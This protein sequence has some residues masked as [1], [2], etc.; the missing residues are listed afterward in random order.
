[1]TSGKKIVLYL[2]VLYIS[3]GI[4][5]GAYLLTSQG[6]NV[7]VFIGSWAPN[8]S[9]LIVL[10]FILKER[11]G[12]RNLLKRWLQWRLPF[13]SYGLSVIYLL[14]VGLS[15][16]LYTIFGGKMKTIEDFQLKKVITLVPLLLIT[17]A[18]GEELGWRGFMLSELQKKYSG[19]MSALIISPFWIIFHIPLWLRPELGYSGIPFIVFSLSTVG[20][21]VTLAY[22]VNR[23][24]GSLL[25]ASLAHFCGNFGLAFVPALGMDPGR[26]FLIYGL[27]NVLYATI[28]VLATGKHLGNGSR[29]HNSRG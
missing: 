7:I 24:R 17:G 2:I 27:L 6:N 14:I 4:L 1:M 12:V 22:L 9:A 8:L 18:T 3:I 25:V 29:S 20:L 15:I 26:L 11:H 5:S 23:S 28:I 21:S 10:G 19:L 16:F 13:S